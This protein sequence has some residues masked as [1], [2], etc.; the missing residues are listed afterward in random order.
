MGEIRCYERIVQY[1]FFV[2]TYVEINYY[3]ETEV[4]ISNQLINFYNIS[5]PLEDLIYFAN[6]TT[7]SLQFQH[8]E[9]LPNCFQH[10]I[11]AQYW[12]GRDTETG[13]PHVT[14]FV[15]P[16]FVKLSFLFRK[17]LGDK[18]LEG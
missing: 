11:R 18:L 4:L 7:C 13:C 5:E 2:C 8:P 16:T 17:Y 14:R 9:C 3:H 12:V 1:F 10:Y 15:S 6:L